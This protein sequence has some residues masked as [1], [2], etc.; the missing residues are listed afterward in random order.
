M[1]SLRNG[2]EYIIRGVSAFV[3][4][5]LRIERLDE[6]ETADEVTLLWQQ[7][8][9]DA[10]KVEELAALNIRWKEK[11]IVVAMDDA[12]RETLVDDVCNALL[13]LMS[14]KRA[15]ESRWVTMGVVCRTICAARLCG[16]DG[17]L[18]Y[19]MSQPQT[20]QYYIGGVTRMSAEVMLYAAV[21]AV[22]SH[23]PDGFLYELLQDDRVGARA[24]YLAE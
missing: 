19:V 4:T 23:V 1:E 10:G 18:E 2:Y 15:T 14:F 11:Q 20:S 21:A 17:L 12:S 22:S 13:F 6:R 24:Q 16:L 5:N 9:A 8:C 7:L 3:Q